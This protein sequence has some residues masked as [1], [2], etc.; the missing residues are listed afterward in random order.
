M[1]NG[2]GSE[3]IIEQPAQSDYDDM[4]ADAKYN[5]HLREKYKEGFEKKMKE[6]TVQGMS[7]IRQVKKI[8]KIDKEIAEA[9]SACENIEEG[10]VREVGRYVGG[11]RRNVTLNDQNCNFFIDAAIAELNEG[12]CQDMKISKSLEEQT[13]RCPLYGFVNENNFNPS[14]EIVPLKNFA[15]TLRK[16]ELEFAKFGRTTGFT[17]EGFV[18]DSV[19]KM[20]VTLAF[21]SPPPDSRYGLPLIHV[22]HLYCKDCIKSYT[23]EGTSS[24]ELSK[25]DLNEIPCSKCGKMLNAE[26]ENDVKAED[27]NDVIDGVHS[28]VKVK[29]GVWFYWAH[30]C[31]VIRKNREPFIK[32]G[33]SGAIVFDN[34]GLAWGLVF[35]TFTD[36]L[37]NTDYCLASPLCVALKALEQEFGIKELKLW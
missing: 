27:K 35:G 25:Q 17:D 21:D 12:E 1:D 5:L 23:E 7:D 3:I 9:K 37:K 6:T 34:K 20:F 28:D 33:D 36:P 8:K 29:D 22:Q 19:P 26:D 31:F 2:S 11:L 30:N 14:G 32:S 10:T 13:N 16:E 4:I 15:E 24:K 18:E